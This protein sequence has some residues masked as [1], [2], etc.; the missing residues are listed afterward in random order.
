MRKLTFVFLGVLFLWALVNGSSEVLEKEELYDTGKTRKFTGDALQ[1]IAFPIGGLGTGNITLGGRGEIRELEIFNRPDKGTY[2]DFTFFS[3]WAKEEGKESVAR[4]LERRFFPPYV[5]WMGIPRNQL[6]GVSRFEEVIFRGEY[7][8]AYLSF[9]DKDIPV[10]VKLEAYNPFIPLS[11]E[12]SGVPSAVFH[13]KIK[14]KKASPVS[15]SLAFSMLNP[16]KTKDESNR[17]GFGKNINQYIDD[18][19][20][21]G[22]K[23]TSNRGAEKD[24]EFGSLAFVTTEKDVDVQTS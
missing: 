10:E 20:F 19:K 6:P 4:I 13:W 7:P 14:N 21:R 16:I 5:A 11:P 8:F 23:M 12:K 24:I 17:I 22:I 9:M 1:T 3:L 15:V 2:P 18:G